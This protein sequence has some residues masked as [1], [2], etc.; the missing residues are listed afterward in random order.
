[1]GIFND[2]FTLQNTTVRT[3]IPMRQPEHRRQ[4]NRPRHICRDGRL[5]LA[6]CASGL[7]GYRL[8][9]RYGITFECER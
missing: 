1:M 4:A 2:H 6:V 8:V 3:L 5:H 9:M 7:R